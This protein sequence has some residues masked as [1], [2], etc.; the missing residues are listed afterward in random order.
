MLEATRRKLGEARFFYQRLLNERQQTFRHDPAAFRYYFSAFIQAARSVTWALGKEEKEKWK[1]WEPKWEST[2]ADE[3]KKLLAFTNKLR[4]DEVHR[5]GTNPTVELEE[6][7]LHELLSANLDVEPRPIAAYPHHLHKLPGVAPST[8]SRPVY[9][10]EHEDG[11]EE[12]TALCV[13]YLE[14]L[15]KM[16]ND[17]SADN[18]PASSK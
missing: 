1:A 12:V 9:Y 8:A 16:V 10:F 5:G 2:L 7:A 3:D 4:Q 17:Y 6:V 13:R 18:Y 14:F 15:E 11:K